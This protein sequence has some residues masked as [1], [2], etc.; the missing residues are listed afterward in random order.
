MCRPTTTTPTSSA[1]AGDGAEADSKAE[2]VPEAEVAVEQQ[3]RLSDF[4]RWARKA[5]NPMV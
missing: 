5:L 2:D 4:M 3:E 1:G